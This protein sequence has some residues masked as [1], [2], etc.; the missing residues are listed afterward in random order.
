MTVN[1]HA[2]AAYRDANV[3]TAD[4]RRLLLLL[5]DRM[6]LDVERGLLA[7]QARN[8]PEAH[9]QLVHAQAIVM[10]LRGS[11]RTEDFPGG[12]RLGAIYDH[13]H[14]ELVLANVH[15]DIDRTRDCLDLAAAITTTWHEASAATH[16]VVAE[17]A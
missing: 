15:K 5:C 8:Y 11:L 4:P 1:T 3:V 16:A 6:V 13:L 17:S 9:N 7:Q 2:Y 12:D 10:E 14:R